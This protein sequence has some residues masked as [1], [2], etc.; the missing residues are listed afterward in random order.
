MNWIFYSFVVRYLIFHWFP[1]LGLLIYLDKI[2]LGYKK[3]MYKIY[4]I[5]INK[6]MK[7]NNETIVLYN[8]CVN[9]TSFNLKNHRFLMIFY[10]WNFFF[11]I[12]FYHGTPTLFQ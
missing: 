2:S 11:F 1:I 12:H 8:L 7:K 5:Q 6:Y 3:N 4:V 10:P 9:T